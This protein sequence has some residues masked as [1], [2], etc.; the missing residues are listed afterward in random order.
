MQETIQKMHYTHNNI[1]D[2]VP[3][4]TPVHGSVHCA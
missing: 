1:L 4:E 2:G 3:G